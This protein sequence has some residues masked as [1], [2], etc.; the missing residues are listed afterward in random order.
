MLRVV[1]VKASLS[2]RYWNLED[3]RKLDRRYDSR[4]WTYD[5]PG[6]IF[7]T[8]PSPVFS[9]VSDSSL[10]GESSKSRGDPLP[11]SRRCYSEDVCINTKEARG[12]WAQ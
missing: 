8:C 5:V 1:H 4:C 7:Y 2:L 12:G 6:Y 10:V 9:A 3:G 11:P